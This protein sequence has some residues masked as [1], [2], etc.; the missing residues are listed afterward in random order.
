MTTALLSRSGRELLD[1]LAG[2]QIHRRLALRGLGRATVVITRA[3]GR[4]WGLVCADV[5]P[6][7]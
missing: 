5:A 7:T 6:A 3:R 4:P 1:Q 2:E